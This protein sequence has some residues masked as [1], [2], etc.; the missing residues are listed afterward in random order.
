MLKTPGRAPKLSSGCQNQPIAKVAVCRCS[1]CSGSGSRGHSLAIMR[2]CWCRPTAARAAR[3]VETGTSHSIFA[4]GEAPRGFLASRRSRGRRRIRGR[5]SSESSGVLPEVRE[6][7]TRHTAYNKHDTGWA[8]GAPSEVGHGVASNEVLSCRWLHQKVRR[9]AR[10]GRSPAQARD[11]VL[12]GCTF[13]TRKVRSV[14]LSRK[15]ASIV[16]FVMLLPRVRWREKSGCTSPGNYW[17]ASCN[18]WEASSD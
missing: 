16:I 9:L 13:Y 14:R 5:E 8:K 12:M 4:V 11:G 2:S 15:A 1:D 17:E 6:F 10:L 7:I 18:Y 3:P